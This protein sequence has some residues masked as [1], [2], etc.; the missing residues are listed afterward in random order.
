MSRIV[1][2]ILKSNLNKNK[3]IKFLAIKGGKLHY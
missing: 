3:K 1:K 2:I